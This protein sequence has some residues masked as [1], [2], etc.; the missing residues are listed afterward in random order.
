MSVDTLVVAPARLPRVNLLPQE[1]N[2]A[3]K[4]RQVK[5]GLV[6]A[7]VVSAVGMGYLTMTAGS[8][9]TTAQTSYDAAQTKTQALQAEQSK[10]AGITSL[11]AQVTQREMLLSTAMA[12][13][14]RWAGFLNDVRIAIPRGVRFQTWA[15]TVTP[16]TAQSGQPLTA[17]GSGGVA[18]WQITGQ[19]K[20]YEDVAKLIESL[21]K[22]Q[23]VDSAYTT[24][25]KKEADSASKKVVYPFTLQA[26]VS[27]DATA[28]YQPK[29][30]R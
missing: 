4:A 26:R 17:F 14:V 21:Y 23:A 24:S 1:I 5:L 2:E 19:G 30:D 12:D 16:P 3:N 25:V 13:N 6:A 20:S 9:V 11:K 28:P 15:V 22:M 29:A 27:Q 10:H 8:Q 18:T 7:V